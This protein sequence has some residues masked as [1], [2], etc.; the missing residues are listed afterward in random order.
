MSTQTND[1]RLMACADCGENFLWTAEEQE[2]YR[3]KGYDPPRRCKEC[4]QAKKERNAD[5]ERRRGG[6][7]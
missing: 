6:A 4:R 7:G 5:R 2:H 3:A 1:D